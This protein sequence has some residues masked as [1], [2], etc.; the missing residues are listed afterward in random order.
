MKPQILPLLLSVAAAWVIP[1]EQLSSSLTVEDQ[2][3]KAPARPWS[4]FPSKED[5][6]GK[7]KG[8][9]KKGKKA[10]KETFDDLYERLPGKETE[11]LIEDFED[12]ALYVSSWLDTADSLDYLEPQDEN[13]HPRPPPHH[14]PGK[15]PKHPPHPPKRPHHPPHHGKPN[16]TVYQ[17]IANFKHST[18]LT[19]LINLFPEVVELLN[20]T[21]SNFTI[22]APVDSAFEKIPKH[23]KRP[24]DEIMKKVLLYHVAPGVFPAGRVLYEHTVPTALEEPMLDAPQR[25]AARLS[26]RGPTLNFYSRIFAPN[27]VSGDT[28][29]SKAIAHI[30]I[31][32]LAMASFM[33]S[34][35]FCSRH[36]RQSQLS[37]FCPVTFPL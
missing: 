1:D 8:H 25:I 23:G 22:F 34:T 15:R 7:L 35:L 11:Y 21:A 30:H 36:Q 33:A 12:A 24:S 18:K 31:R 28:T 13:P 3:E 4:V 27:V 20:S 26:L 32:L 17:I 6:I 19:K 16:E 14:P 5:L 9:A 29:V 2:P 10:A 37:S